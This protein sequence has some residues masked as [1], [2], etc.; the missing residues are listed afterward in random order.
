[1]AAPKPM[2]PMSFVEDISMSALCPHCDAPLD[3]ILAREVDLQGSPP[4]RFGKR[5]A[6]ACPS[7][8]RLHGISHRKGFWMG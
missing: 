1:M 2:T 7:C 5:F 8:S 3:T 4:A 6:Y